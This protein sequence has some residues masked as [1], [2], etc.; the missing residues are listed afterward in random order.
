MPDKQGN[1]QT[2]PR[3]PRWQLLLDIGSIPAIILLILGL[4]LSWVAYGEYQQ[5]KEAEF[6]L[7]EAHA[8][9]ASVQV[10][11]ALNKVQRMLSQ[12]SG[13]QQ[14]TRSRANKTLAALAAPY[15][16]ELPELGTLL[17]SDAAGRIRMATDSTMVGQNI[18]G[19]DCFSAHLGPSQPSTLFISRPEKPLLGGVSVVFSLPMHDA[20]ARFLGIVGASIGFR[21]F[22]QVLQTIN[23]DDSASMSVIF[24][25]HGDLLFRRQEPEK[26]FGNNI[27]KIS[28]VFNAHVDAG[29]PVTRHIGPSAQNGKLR[30]FLVHDVGD[31]GLTLILSRQLDEVLASWRN[32]VTGYALIFIFTGVVLIYLSHVAVQRKRQILAGKAFSEQLIATA[33][34]M[35]LGLDSQCRITI[36]NE[37]AERISGYGREEVLGRCWIELAVPLQAASSVRGM[38]EYF[39]QG[40]ALPHDVEYPILT[41][42]GQE[43]TI[44]W[45]N[46]VMAQ[47]RA[48]ISFGI[49]VTE[50]KLMELALV[51]ARQEAEDA[52]MGK[53]KFLAAASH[54]LRQPIHAQGLFLEVLSRTELNAQQREL[55]ASSRAAS[56][57]SADM[58]NTLL[59]FSRIEAGVIEPQRQ[60][61]RVQPLLNKI[62]REFER[63]A[64]AKGLAYRSRETVL[65]AQ[66]D[67]ALIELILRNLV[68]NAIRYT[69]CGGVLVTC[70]QRAGQVVLEVWDTGIGITA[71]QQREVFREFHQLGNPE[72]DRRKGLGLGLAI[73]EGLARTLGHKLSLVSIPGRGSV[74]RLALPTATDP[75]MAAELAPLLAKSQRLDMRVLVIDDE[76][77]VRVGMLH[78]LHSWGCDCVAAESIEDALA[79]ARQQAPDFV[80]SDYRLREQRT[81]IEA[82]AALRALLGDALPALL[83]T[84]DTAPERLRQAQA[85]GIPLLNKPVSPGQLY[86]AMMTLFKAAKNQNTF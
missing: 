13:A 35:V 68:S 55:L 74:F 26:F 18:S 86:R 78:L 30:L 16:E 66:S 32:T 58:L 77:S 81:G 71:S 57:A 72:R 70:R 83:V 47:P 17:V 34:V 5:I 31:S 64:D 80:I 38:F 54:D 36:F 27:S 84:G 25:R 48:A 6:R 23:P 10:S 4:T 40:G 43:R 63:Q 29:K 24:N 49:D 12:I 22:P 56:D 51:A 21:F 67:P 75:A 1:R 73:V 20:H 59:D 61:F 37:T 28:T 2:Q 45:Q 8:R 69:D 82:I 60:A 46:S 52:N 15:R 33:N 7:L 9:N 44:A 39:D 76:E 42:T 41:K 14:A 79:L 19:K 11:S 85:S 3:P 62:E 65:V 53:S 50:R